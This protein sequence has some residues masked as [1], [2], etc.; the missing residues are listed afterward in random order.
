MALQ[1]FLSTLINAFCFLVILLL[2]APCFADTKD[3]SSFKFSG[4]L[5]IYYALYSDSVGL[6]NYSKFPDIS[7]RNNTFGLN[8]F[9]LSC[10]YDASNLRATATIHYGDLPQSAWSPQFN[11][12]QEANLGF[13]INPKLWIDAGLFKTHIGTEGFLPKDNVASSMSVITY[14][15]PWW[16]AGIKATYTYSEKFSLAVHLLNGY[17]TFLNFNNNKAVG[18]AAN[19]TFN[20][21]ANLGYFNLL[22]DS[23]PD[24]VKT[25]HLRFLNNF[26]FTYQFTSKLKGIAGFDFISQRNSSLTDPTKSAYIYSGIVTLRYQYKPKIAVYGRY[27]LY[28]DADGFLSG[29]II[30]DNNKATGLILNGATLGLEFKPAMNS[31]IRLEGRD[32]LMNSDEKIFIT[33]GQNTHIRTELMITAGV[34]F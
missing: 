14:Y 10:H 9:Q 19:Y 1:R 2:N 33:N 15:E 22:S 17:N 13:R 21:R 27:E 25:S 23:S 31:F 30:D 5:D 20:E 29:I 18:I 32:M 11:I 24:S 3:S 16:Q 6:N 26:V 12:L 28:H 8:I 34:W 7:T 4:Y